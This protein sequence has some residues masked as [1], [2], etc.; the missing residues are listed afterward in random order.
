[1]ITELPSGAI[2]DKFSKQDQNQN[3]K[4]GPYSIPNL[5]FLVQ[6]RFGQFN[7]HFFNFSETKGSGEGFIEFLDITGLLTIEI[8]ILLN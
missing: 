8:L 7:A 6:I 4:K 1:M 5:H 3:T 2:W